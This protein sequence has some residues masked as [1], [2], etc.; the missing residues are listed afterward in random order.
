VLAVYYLFTTRF[1]SNDSKETSRAKQIYFIL[2]LSVV[3]FLL[4]GGFSPVWS[5]L[6]GYMFT[7]M[8]SKSDEGLGLHFYS[9][10]QTIREANHIPFE[11]FANRISGH[12][13]TFVVSVFGYIYLAYR[14]KIMLFAL[15][16]IGLGFLAYVGGLRFTI[17]AVPVLALGI[18]FLIT[19]IARLM[20]TAKLKVL[21][22]IAFTLMIIY[23]NYKHIE[24]YRVPTVFN[25]DEVKLISKLKDIASREDYVIG[26]WD[27]GY[28]L[29][30]YADVKTLGDG[31]KHSGSVNFPIS[32]ILTSPQDVAAKLARLDVE[33][34]ERLFKFKKEN[35]EAIKNEEVKVFTNIEEMT[36]DYGF[37]D[38]NDFLLSLET[39]I[40]L[41]E[42]TRD[43]Y[44]YLPFRM[45]NIY[46][47]VDIFS[48]IDLM[49]GEMK[50]QNLFF[51]SRNFRQNGDVVDLGRGVAFNVK[52]KTIQ[53]GKDVVP[54]RRLVRTNYTKGM[55]LNVKVDEFNKNAPISVIF[56]S[57]YN[58]FL[59]V[60]EKNY[61]SLYIQLFVLEN[62]DKNIFEKVLANPHAKI[63][64]LKI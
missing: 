38:T 52:S 51:L 19:E 14:H 47:T 31:G 39:N 12:V 36:K 22:M 11:T 43:I 37:D 2:V 15:P 20:P 46:P 41:P 60:D 50:K 63:Y 13:V 10:M 55:N 56:M 6:K 40:T 9:V 54:L 34:T 48:N 62:Y 32:F 44:I 35:E 53:I 26:W 61:N 16:M 7:D 8:V 59:V 29:R 45:S 21:S 30:Y 58:T 1:N 4:S 33:Y 49:S 42:K 64:K 17:Y 24:S 5:Q 25:A 23:P 3:L 28:P 57:D 18:A 27:Y